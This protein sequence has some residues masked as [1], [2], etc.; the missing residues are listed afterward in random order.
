VTDPAAPPLPRP[1]WFVRNWKWLVPGGCLFLFLLM[2]GFAAGVFFL[3]TGMM[4]Q[5]D[6]Y[7][8]ALARAKENPAVIEAPGT[9][10]SEGLITS[11]STHVSGPGG[12]ANI[13]I[14][15]HGAKGKGT[16]YVVA[17]KAANVW[18]FTTLVVEI[19]ATYQRI[20]LN[21]PPKT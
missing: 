17:Y 4:K 16:I 9:P 2:I 8:I 13:A 7:K 20:D 1:N 14:P 21:A 10:I 3:A 19:E 6:A 15:I 5:S 12:D 18:Q 11:G